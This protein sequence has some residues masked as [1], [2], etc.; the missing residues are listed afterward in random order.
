VKAV[1]TELEKLRKGIDRNMNLTMKMDRYL[2]RYAPVQ[3]QTLI[4]DTLRACLT[5]TARR[6]HEL[7]NHEKLGMLYTMLLAEDEGNTSEVTK[8]ELEILDMNQTACKA[9]EEY[10]K[11]KKARG[12]V[13]VFASSPEKRK[14]S[15][16]PRKAS[17]QDMEPESP[18]K[19]S[20][21]DA[22]SPYPVAASD[23]NRQSEMDQ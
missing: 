12:E 10:E 3:T 21:M 9:V 22:E 15:N 8:V 11:A 23:S 7:Y 13:D 1:D 16:R 14:P 20:M 19:R 18:D 5:G 4:G 2:N 6:S 17:P